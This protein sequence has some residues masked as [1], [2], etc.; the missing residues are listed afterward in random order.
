MTLRRFDLLLTIAMALLVG[1]LGALDLVSPAVTGGTTLATLG[2]LA[3]SSLHS[4]SAL[5]ALNQSVADLDHDLNG[6]GSADQLL[7]RSTF[8]ADLDLGTTGDIRIMGVTLA[9]TLRSQ[10]A[11]LGQRLDHGAS[12]RIALIAP[13]PVTLGEAA[14]RSTMA[15]NPEIFEHRLRPTM[16]LLD[17]LAARA[18][19]GPGRLRI[20]LLDFVPA[21]GLIALDPELPHGQAHVEVYS[22]RSGTPEPTLPLYADPDP[23]WLRHFTAE[24]DKVWAAGKPYGGPQSVGAPARGGQHPQGTRRIPEAVTGTQ[25]AADGGH[26]VVRRTPGQVNSGGRRQLQPA[27]DTGM[28]HHDGTHAVSSRL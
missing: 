22:H 15:D 26:G 4:R 3:I 25:Q 27:G 16:D 5:A 9:R 8:G 7:G 2:L 1:V 18:A 11:A 13:Q 6:R 14:R 12:V 21:F 28:D 20:R 10:Y 19:G 17:D 23:Y 24:F